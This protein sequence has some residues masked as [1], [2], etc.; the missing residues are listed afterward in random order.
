MKLRPV[1]MF[2]RKFFR[3]ANIDKQSA[4]IHHLFGDH[5]CNGFYG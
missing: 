4:I 2:T 3:L 5:R 1:N